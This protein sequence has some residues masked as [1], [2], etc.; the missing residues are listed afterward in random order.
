M[1]DTNKYT[2][3]MDGYTFDNAPDVVQHIRECWPE[4]YD[5]NVNT[6]YQHFQG[7]TSRNFSKI[8]N[9]ITRDPVAYV[10]CA[11]C[12]KHIYLGLSAVIFRCSK[13]VTCCSYR[14]MS[15]YLSGNRVHSV[16]LS[17]NDI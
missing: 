13:P 11:V 1:I 12:H 7:K 3:H 17:K 2:Y 9:M 10:D 8:L 14:C 5:I 15:R 4:Y 16:I 6:I